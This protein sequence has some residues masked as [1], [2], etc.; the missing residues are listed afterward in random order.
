MGFAS[1]MT[2]DTDESIMNEATG[3]PTKVKILMV[4]NR[5]Y[6]EGVTNDGYLRFGGKDYFEI[7]ARDNGYSEKDCKDYFEDGRDC[8][9]HDIGTDLF[10]N[11]QDS[12]EYPK[13]VSMDFEGGYLDVPIRIPK[14]CPLQGYWDE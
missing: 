13:V 6:M 12:V 9:F 14:F 1:F 3:N 5:V 11:H 8:D 2:M 7:L 4:G 10:Y